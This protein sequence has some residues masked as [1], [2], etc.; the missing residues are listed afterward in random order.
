[1]PYF[2]GISG[3][4]LIKKTIGGSSLDRLSGVFESMNTSRRSTASP[5]VS[6]A[7]V[8][9]SWCLSVYMNLSA[10]ALS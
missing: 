6:Y 4:Y 5:I 10:C 1:V 3:L 7:N 8:K 9:I 2:R